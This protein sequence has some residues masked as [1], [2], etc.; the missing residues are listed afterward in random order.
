M[1]GKIR[2][3]RAEKQQKSKWITP[4]LIFFVA[5]FA[6]SAYFLIDYFAKAQVNA[7]KYDEIGRFVEQKRNEAIA[8][9]TP[10]PPPDFTAEEPPI[11]GILP[12]YRELYEQN[13]DLVGWIKI[14]GTFVD[15][16]VTMTP[17]NPNYYLNRDFFK[18]SDSYGTPFADGGTSFYPRSTNV[19]IYG[20]HMKSGQMFGSLEGYEARAYWEAHP[21]INFDT[22][23]E[24]GQ[25]EVF[26]AFRA[27]AFGGFD[28][29]SF[30][31][32]DSQKEFDNFV[33]SCKRRSKIKSDI[34]PEFGDYLVTLITCEYQLEDG[35]YLVVARKID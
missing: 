34:T 4:L 28:F 27:E 10:T 2:R 6:V 22:L 13:N 5:V 12:E 21:I 29:F 11:T 30:V 8:D 18:K 26:A 15:Y 16:P 32:A 20:H 19:N 9:I 7:D 33:A 25:Y 31:D 1:E 14:P 35:R 17:K 24:R 23:Y 3:S